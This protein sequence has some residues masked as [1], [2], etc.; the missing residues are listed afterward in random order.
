MDGHDLLDAMEHIDP[1][2]IDKAA[3]SPDSASWRWLTWY[4]VAAC[5]VLCLAVLAGS[6]RLGRGW[7]DHGQTQMDGGEIYYN[8]AKYAK[9]I[10]GDEP[11]TKFGEALTQDELEMAMPD[12]TED[13]MAFSGIAKYDDMGT[14]KNI[15]LMIRDVDQ[16]LEVQVQFWEEGYFW[17]DDP[18]N[19]GVYLLTYFS[20]GSVYS[21]PVDAVKSKLGDRAF[22]V[23]QITLNDTNSTKL[24]TEF[25]Q[26]GRACVISM[27]VHNT[28][29]TRGKAH[30][31]DVLA[32][33][34]KTDHAPDLSL[35]QAKNQYGRTGLA[36]VYYNDTL[37]SLSVGSLPYVFEE[38]LTDAEL[39]TAVPSMLLQNMDVSG[40]AVYYA[41]DGDVYGMRLEISVPSWDGVVSV[42]MRQTPDEVYAGQAPISGT[43]VETIYCWRANEQHFT[44]YRDETEGL[45][46]HL[47]V[48]FERRGVYYSISA[49]ADAAEDTTEAKKILEKV[50][51]YFMDD[52]SI[53]PDLSQLAHKNDYEFIHETLTLEE[54]QQHETF[55]SWMLREVPEGFT[56]N[57]IRYTK[58]AG[59]DTLSS[60]W[61]TEGGL[62]RWEITWLEENDKSRIT[63]IE[64]RENY[65][66][67]LYPPRL[68]DDWYA[69]VSNE[70]WDILE[71]PIFRIEELTPEAI[72]ART[73]TVEVAYGTD[74]RT[75]T[76]GVLYGDVLVHIYASNV[77][78]D[79]LYAQLQALK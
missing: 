44:A 53:V 32:C 8:T 33:Y 3:T 74:K 63:A 5:L 64:D 69:F 48:E 59:Q 26:E 2:L 41:W 39:R 68:S 58:D 10:F 16:E 11:Y 79:W 47:W 42:L 57:Y 30:F 14:L 56:E 78:P 9:L 20:D 36:G 38:D 23:Y 46:T 19:D 29:L 54:A 28:Q 43:L 73:D 45:Q 72:Y 65:D 67:S 76:F 6:W 75:K 52:G 17:A 62:L 1:E 40:Q 55:G 70:R 61:S 13:W 50:V 12:V 22:T 27:Q 71:D 18:S 25:Q 7:L 21:V 35:I 51:M 60:S 31:E 66:L 24:W 15:G 49:Y 37:P 77:D 34:A 4:A